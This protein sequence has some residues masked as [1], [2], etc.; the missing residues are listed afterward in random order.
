MRTL[1]Y[2]AFVSEHVTGVKVRN[3]L[4]GLVMEFPQFRDLSQPTRLPVRS[5]DTSCAVSV[6]NL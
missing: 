3:F 2:I 4:D 6:A 1:L 5:P